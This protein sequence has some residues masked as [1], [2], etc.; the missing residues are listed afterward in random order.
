MQRTFGT[1]ELLEMIL[2]KLSTPSLL[3]AQA[4][5]HQFFNAIER[6]RSLQQKMMLERSGSPF[7]STL[8]DKRRYPTWSPRREMYGGFSHNVGVPGAGW[9]DGPHR[10]FYEGNPFVDMDFFAY[11]EDGHDLPVIGARCRSMFVCEPVITK[12]TMYPDCCGSWAESEYSSSKSVSEFSNKTGVTIGDLHDAVKRVRMEQQLCEGG[13]WGPSGPGSTT[14]VTFHSTIKL[15]SD[16]PVARVYLDI[17]VREEENGSWDGED[18]P[19]ESLEAEDE[20]ADAEDETYEG[21]HAYAGA[22]EIGE[23][24]CCIH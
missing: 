7:F 5:N 9:D 13:S 24:Y 20:P 21:V 17:Y 3:A 22:E 8:L 11:F 14:G 16:D 4:V 19:A 15:R 1:T 2:L 23:G 12:M 10:A 18:E 6:T